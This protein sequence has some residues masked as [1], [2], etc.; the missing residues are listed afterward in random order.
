MPR[1]MIECSPHPHA[2]L[3]AT[4][5]ARVLRFLPHIAMAITRTIVW[6]GIALLPAFAA[7]A[8]DGIYIIFDAS[9]SMWE[10][11]PGGTL[12][13][14]AAKSALKEFLRGD[15]GGSDVA[16]RVYGHRQKGDCRDS[17]LV[18]PFAA[19]GKAIPLIAAA[20]AGIKPVGKTPITLSF[21]EALKDF[22]DRPGGII[23]IS[24]GIESCDAD[25]CALM[26]AWRDK[27][28]RIRVHVIGLGLDERS[29]TALSC[30]SNAAGTRYHDASSAA[31]L[32]KS[33]S[34]I[35]ETVVSG[36]VYL[37][38]LDARQRDRSAR[39]TLSRTGAPP[40][41]VRTH[42]RNHAEPGQ[43]ILTAGI[44]TIDGA[45]YRPV[46][47]SVR[48][49]ELGRADLAIEVEVPPSVKP[50]FT[51][52]GKEQRLGGLIDVH[53]NGAKIAQFRAIDKAFLPEGTYELRA[54]SPLGQS[55]VSVT[56]KTGDALTP[57]F[58]FAQTVHV[59]L[60]MK[61][62]GS[63]IRFPGNFELWQGS[64]QRASVHRANGARVP[65]GKYSVRLINDL[66]PWTQEILVTAEEKQRF[67]L[68]VSAA[69]LVVR[70][71]KRDGSADEDKRYFLGAGPAERGRVKQSGQT[72]PLTPGTY[73]IVGWG[74]HYD[75][76][77]IEVRSG[78]TKEVVLKAKK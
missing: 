23:L 37:K 62:S 49:D 67:E 6:I 24:D 10:R 44:E 7:M 56:L 18:V 2:A 76:V 35:R 1:F 32:A 71:R 40:V 64:E 66:T 48:V 68:T 14:D 5:T 51:S 58:D 29:R 11:L 12:R 43:Y 46:G 74:G 60:E 39:G 26:K 78:D 15:F 69:H 75:T 77:V 3:L 31:D 54:S 61:A 65:P 57:I 63:G 8:D 41:A 27:N 34:A 22:G 9:G 20:V 25:P 42:A 36:G 4:T 59:I 47:K 45:L 70:Y 17:Q 28:V 13:I 55:V 72:I 52:A 50:R 33:L 38:A 16:L 53:R 73:N 19:P 30:M 21:Q